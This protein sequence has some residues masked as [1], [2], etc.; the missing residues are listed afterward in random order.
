MKGITLGLKMTDSI[1]QRFNS[2]RWHDSKLLGLCFYREGSEELV[3]ISL[4][5]LEKDGILKPVD[6]LFRESTYI[7]LE[8][9]LEAKSQ[10]SDDISDAE[11]LAE[12]ELLRSLTAGNPYDSFEGYLQ[13]RISLIPP[14]GAINILAKDFLFEQIGRQAT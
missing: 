6:L 13:F 1:I 14:G 3:K 10:C 11:C 2:V 7:K 12:S 8:V 5:L 4:K 9:D